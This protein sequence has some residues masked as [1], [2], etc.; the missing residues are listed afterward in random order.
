MRDARFE[1]DEIR[2]GRYLFSNSPSGW[3]RRIS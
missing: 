2:S 3:L 1:V